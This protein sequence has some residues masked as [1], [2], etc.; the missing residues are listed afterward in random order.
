[1]HK[2]RKYLIYVENLR[3]R[4]PQTIEV[5]DTSERR[6]RSAIQARPDYKVIHIEAR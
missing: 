1:M 6:A 4:M 2:L 5:W 3:T